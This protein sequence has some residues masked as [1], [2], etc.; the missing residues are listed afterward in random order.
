MA[1][2]FAET[3]LSPLGFETVE[4]HETRGYTVD[5]LTM[6]LGEIVVKFECV[7]PAYPTIK[8]LGCSLHHEGPGDS[9][10]VVRAEELALS[11][12]AE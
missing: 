9:W 12:T 5:S 1:E 3:R 2:T 6:Q 7:C 10:P 4:R 11:S 8:A